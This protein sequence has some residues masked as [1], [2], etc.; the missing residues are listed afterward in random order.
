MAILHRA[1]NAIEYLNGGGATHNGN[2]ARGWT[3]QAS[4]RSDGKHAQ[5]DA[6]DCW[7]AADFAYRESGRARRLDTDRRR[8][9]L[10]V[11]T[12]RRL[13]ENVRRRKPKN[14]DRYG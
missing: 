13:G 5:A 4:W 12:D 11:R 9:G 8:D 7:R 6:R 3:R 10:S 14:P 1:P 2:P